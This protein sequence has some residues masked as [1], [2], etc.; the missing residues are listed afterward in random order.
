MRRR[1]VFLDRDGTINARAPEGEYV[2]SVHALAYLPGA[3]DAIRELTRAGFAVFVV[4][5]QRGI[6][7]GKMTEDD[8]A[9]IHERLL[10]DVRAAGG[11]IERV[12]YCPHDLDSC[13]CRKP[14]PGLFLRA[15]RQFQWLE[16]ASAWVVGDSASDV[17]AAAAVGARSVLLAGPGS[18]EAVERRAAG[19]PVAAHLADAVELIRLA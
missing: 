1:A 12:Y 17:E 6:A 10:R 4:T 16:L 5:N 3:L 13:D 14:A 19:L 8:L 11:A 2:T 15:A 9:A 7:L 18:V